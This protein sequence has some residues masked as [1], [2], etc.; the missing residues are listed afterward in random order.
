MTTCAD[1]IVLVFGFFIASLGLVVAVA[2][3]A[4]ERLIAAMFE[5]IMQ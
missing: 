2:P 5:A 3:V 4:T 1:R